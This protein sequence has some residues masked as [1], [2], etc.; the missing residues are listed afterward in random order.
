MSWW[1]RGQQPPRPF[2]VADIAAAVK[3]VTAAGDV[4]AAWEAAAP[5]RDELAQVT[6]ADA[7]AYCVPR[8]GPHRG[9]ELGRA[10]LAQHGDHPAVLARLGAQVPL[11]TDSD[12]L[13]APPPDEPWFAELVDRLDR[14]VTAATGDAEIALLDALASAARRLGRAGDARAERAHATLCAREPDVAH[15]HY[16]AGLFFKTRGRWA[17]GQ[18]ANQRAIE[19]GD[20]DE[21]TRWNLALCATGAGDGATALAAWKHLGQHVELGRFGLPDGTYP[22]ANV[23][24]AQRPLAERTADVDSPGVEENVWIERVSGGHG[25]VRVAV[26]AEALGVDYGDVVMFDGAPIGRRNGVPLFPHLATVQRGGYQI[27]P[28]AGTQ[29]APGQLIELSAALPDDTVIYPHTEQLQVMC[30]DCARGRGGDG[31]SHADRPTHHVVRGKV[32]APPHLTPAAVLAALDAAIA[33]SPGAQ[34]YC[35]ALCTAA[36]DEAR[37]ATDERRMALLVENV[38][39]R[40]A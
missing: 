1:R 33:T 29:A 9:V 31:H 24:L 26:F 28:F 6:V 11:L 23:R 19:L 17:E 27:W 21:P 10:L 35:P 37:A 40:L 38:D 5:L 34:L 20:D 39:D 32:C 22:A 7:L 14:A 36:G 2:G 12:D 30:A 18:A 15:H 25:I 13:N 4:D 8:F 3:K 16:N